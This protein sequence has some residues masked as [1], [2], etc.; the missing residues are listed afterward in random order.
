MGELNGKVA[1]I[2]GAGSGIGKACTEVFVREGAK[3]FA[4][5]FSGAEKDTAAEVGADV[6]PYH[7][8]LRIEADVAR[9][10]DA[11]VEEFGHVDALLN[12]A[13]TQTGR[14]FE[15]LSDEEWS[16]MTDVNLRGTM[17]ATKHAIQA[18]LRSG[19]G[20]VVNFSS[21]AALNVEALAN[22]SYSIAKA[23]VHAFTKHMAFDYAL[24]G[25]RVNVIAPGFTLT[26]IQKNMSAEK[27]AEMSA[28]P[29]LGRAGDPHETAEVASF[30]ASD[31]SSFVTGAVIPVD[32]GWS[33]RMA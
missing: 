19:G 1:V 32:G 15:P 6:V 22:A 25:V 8:D 28:K 27:L 14:S 24:K 9:M 3:V 17:F 10:I 16:A 7:C 20:S 31:R 23:G 5:D 21:V 26:P 4:I 13:G 12:V 2:T 29:A 11:A 33:I 30:L 18:M